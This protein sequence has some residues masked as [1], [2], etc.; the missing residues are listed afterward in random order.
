MD[1][2]DRRWWEGA[3]GRC[4][5]DV[6]PM[7]NV[8]HSMLGEQYQVHVKDVKVNVTMSKEHWL[9]LILHVEDLDAENDRT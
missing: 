3:C 9:I 6:Q 7:F 4:V 1:F 2:Y 8:V 5:A